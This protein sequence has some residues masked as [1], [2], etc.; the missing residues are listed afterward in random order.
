MDYFSI[1]PLSPAQH[2][3]HRYVSKEMMISVIEMLYHD[4]QL[5]TYDNGMIWKIFNN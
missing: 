4:C 1:H 5:M 3:M 2:A